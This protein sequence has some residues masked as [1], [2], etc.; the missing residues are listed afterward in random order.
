MEL[1]TGDELPSR[2]GR[3]GEPCRRARPA[4]ARDAPVVASRVVERSRVRH[5]ERTVDQRERGEDPIVLGRG[6]LAVAS[7]PRHHDPVQ[8]ALA[9]EDAF[10]AEVSRVVVREL[11]D[12]AVEPADGARRG[13]RGPCRDLP[14]RL[15]DRHLAHALDRDRHRRPAADHERIRVRV[16]ATSVAAP[17][18]APLPVRRAQPEPHVLV[19]DLA[20]RVVAIPRRPV[21]AETAL[22]D[23][24]D[25]PQEERRTEHA[26][27]DVR[28]PR[29]PVDST[30]PLVY[31]PRRWQ[32]RSTS[33]VTRWC[34]TS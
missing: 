12:V 6:R 19:D 31:R 25:R 34:S 27:D 11:A 30:P 13:R 20:R 24:H 15:A 2:Q 23:V 9:H 29:H 22:D 18:H 1:L 7:E 14:G 3:D 26:A 33:S 32:V 4:V 28:A 8:P 21:A 5:A 10:A 17:E 16:L